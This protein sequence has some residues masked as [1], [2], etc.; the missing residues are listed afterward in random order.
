MPSSHLWRPTG[1]AVQL[2]ALGT[3]DRCVWTLDPGHPGPWALDPGHPWQGRMD[4]GPWTLGTPDR[5][6]LPLTGK[7]RPPPSPTPSPSLIP[8]GTIPLG[9]IPLGTT[10]GFVTD[11][12]V[13]RTEC[14]GSLAC[15]LLTQSLTHSLTHSPTHSLAH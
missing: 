10:D 5:Y 7:P 13:T 3:P 6:V 1:L 12:F 11:G 8:L 2:L 14:R 4:P 9:I 15:L